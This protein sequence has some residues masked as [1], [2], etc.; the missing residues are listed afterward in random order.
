MTSI[1]SIVGVGEIGVQFVKTITTYIHIPMIG[2][3]KK[4]LKVLIID[5]EV[6][7]R[8]ILVSI[9]REMRENISPVPLNNTTPK[10]IKSAIKRIQPDVIF[11]G[12]EGDEKVELDL[13]KSIRKNHPNLPIVLMVPL[14]ESGAEITI[15]ALRLGAVE[16]ITKPDKKLGIMLSMRHFRKRV[17]PLAGILRDLNEECL[18][19]MKLSEFATAEV[20]KVA[21]QKTLQLSPNVELIVI[22]GC[23]GGVKELFQLVSGIPQEMPV[24]IVIVQHLPKIYTQKLASD[25]D[26][27]TELNV[28]E[29]QNESPLIPGQIYIAPGG[30]HTVVKSDGYRRVLNIHRGPRENKNRPSIDVLLRSAAQSYKNKLL[31]VFLSGGGPDGI[32]GAKSVYEA[33]GKII[34]QNRESALL[35]KINEK[36]DNQVP[37]LIKSPSHALHQEML[38]QILG[39]RL[40][41]NQRYRTEIQKS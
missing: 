23:T 31:A 5:S 7:I 38:K 39:E 36:I 3:K 27:I 20:Q 2:E 6:L 25:L 9:F 13:V 19:S 29:A 4:S 22:A 14:S 41:K 32:A 17:I 18:A 21:D 28:R 33:G 16:F 10:F 30:Y 26:R 8:Q 1:V 24:P 37:S 35:W 11:L 34:L 15:Q 40:V 12:L